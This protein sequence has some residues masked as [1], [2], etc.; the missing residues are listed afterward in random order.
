MA[1][2]VPRL[3]RTDA[4]TPVSAGRIEGQPVDVTRT[5]A[6]VQQGITN[7]GGAIVDKMAQFEKDGIDTRARAAANQFDQWYNTQ[8]NGDSKAGIVGIKNLQGDPQETYN[9]F[10]EEALKKLEE[11]SIV[12]G[13]S[14]KVQAAV[15]SALANKYNTLYGTR[16][17]LYSQQWDK[18]DQSVTD[19][20]VKAE[21]KLAIDST[22]FVVAGDES[23][24]APFEASLGRI[25]DARIRRALK[26]G[27]AQDSPDG[28][29]LFIDEEG[30]QRRVNLNQSAQVDIAKDFSDA[31]YE[32]ISNLLAADQLDSAKVMMSRYG[33]RLDPLN[34]AK[35][36]EAFNKAEVDSKANQALAK[37]EDKSLP[38]Q[39]RALKALPTDTP[40]KMKIKQEALKLLDA[41]ERYKENAQRRD[42]SEVY[43]AL[44]IGIQKKMTSSQPFTSLYELE[45]DPEYKRLIN[46]VTDAKQRAALQAMVEQPNESDPEAYGA[47]MDDLVNGQFY[48]MTYE[49]LAL[50]KV[51]LSK[52]DAKYFDKELVRHNTESEGAERAKVNFIGSELSRQLN[53]A[54]ILR[55]KNGKLTAASRRE[56]NRLQTK[57][58]VEADKLPK[59]MSVTEQSKWLREV[60]AE[61]IATSAKGATGAA[62]LKK[63]INKF[64]PFAEE[65][66]EEESPI[67]APA[68]PAGIK[69]GK[70]GAITQPS[71]TTEGASSTNDFR[72]MSAKD[73]KK[74]WNDF[75]AEKGVPPANLNELKNWLA[76]KE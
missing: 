9:K 10:D 60:V 35:L 70:R 4:P 7:L 44:A 12:E 45:Q 54:G 19:D 24:L 72:S 29:V 22:A 13:A 34:K 3:Q 14:P 55:Y 17:S 73:Q 21:K 53:A 67:P 48:G 62:K 74:A 1:V 30:V 6:Q 52:S 16:L 42:S 51:G 2:Q 63:L 47:L 23:T 28:K 71:P 33:D 11:L 76:T 43:N 5:L 58:M 15:K 18:Y 75:K 31:T 25:R 37:L 27:T 66:K 32:S 61:E 36:T 49:E 26:I 57:V 8:L 65:E 68:R 40:Q 41:N 50:K 56:L 38:E 46:R 59:N 39:K 64:N 20:A 69:K